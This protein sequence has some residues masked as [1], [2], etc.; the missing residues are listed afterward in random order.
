MISRA[1]PLLFLALCA[2]S[3]RPAPIDD[4][5]DMKNR[6]AGSDL[7]EE[8]AKSAAPADA[9]WIVLYA[10][11][12]TRL[13]GDS[14]SARTLF[15]RVADKY[16]SSP[17]KDPAIL[18]MAVVD[19][20]D[21]PG[22][23]TL[24]TL[25][26]IADK[27]VPDTLNADRYLLLARARQADGAPAEQIKVLTDKAVKYAADA[28]DVSKRVVRAVGELERTPAAPAPQGPPDLA[29]IEEIRRVI[30]SGKLDGLG[31]LATRFAERYPDSPFA[32]EAAY[33]KRRADAGTRVDPALVAV[34]LPSTGAYALP[35]ESLRA[36]FEMGN[37]H[38]GGNLRL[39]FF[40]TAGSG[41]QCSRAVEK[42]ALEQGAALI[43]GP[44]LKEE[45][46]VCA[47]V[48]QAV[49]VPM[50]TLT[51][52]EDALAVGDQ[53]FRAFPSTEQQIAALLT[54]T[55]DVRGLKRYAILHPKTAAGENA[56]RAF[57]AAVTARGGS[58][59]A[60]QSYDPEAKDFRA[61]VKVLGKKDYKAR[62]GEYA[63]LRREAERA[64]A[65]P[66][67]VVLPPLIDYDAIFIPDSYQRVA[68]IASALAFEEFPVGRFRPHQGDTALPLLGLN[69]WNNDELARR[70]GNY[71]LDSIF[72][73]AFDVRAEDLP[74]DNFRSAWR[75]RGK[76]DPT[77][78]EAVAYDTARLLSAA[79]AA[80]GDPAAALFKVK[81][82]DPV[83]GTVG[84]G[85]DRQIQRNWR[86]LT[87]TKEGI[88]PLQPPLPTEPDAG[89]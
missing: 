38:A 21:V 8:A 4:A 59:T 30:R 6:E 72:V 37:K 43:V 7:L 39:A 41:D 1:W 15:E 67:K 51:S 17:A 19:A 33:A 45:A 80:G 54:E 82:V 50:I 16:P 84:F 76:G 78:V 34:L 60:T 36:A 56:A 79:V 55:A 11:E 20:G 22:G 25:G 10:A 83:A 64:K 88:R 52:S 85:P 74:V 32:K 62:A 31:E 14:S 58:V 13:A 29:A 75:E 57:T 42:A 26:L 87:V 47:P 40:D 53:I 71:V 68:L 27:G 23:N 9:P 63:Q 2:A 89:Q 46:A 81:M 3:P 77:V 66:D 70:G 12:L 44:L 35:A 18:G 49:H 65:D 86:L 5:L 48:A 28:K 61:P 24:A 69:P 73:D